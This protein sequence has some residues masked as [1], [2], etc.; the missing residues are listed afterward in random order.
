M[1]KRL[2][3]LEAITNSLRLEVK[4]KSIKIDSLESENTVLKA[5][6]SADFVK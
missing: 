5:A 1:A 3:Q 2:Q 4:E 6:A